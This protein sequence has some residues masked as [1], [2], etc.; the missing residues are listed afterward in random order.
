MLNEITKY[1]QKYAFKKVNIKNPESILK[2]NI[3]GGVITFLHFGDFSFW[4]SINRNFKNKI[5][6]SSIK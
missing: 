5:Y 2:N 6:C 3:K 1:N 4:I